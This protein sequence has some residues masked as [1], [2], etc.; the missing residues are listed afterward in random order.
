[1]TSHETLA[2]DGSVQATIFADGTR[3]VANYS[4]EK[5]DVTGAG[6]IEPQSWKTT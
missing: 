2:A 6:G 4:G 1:M 5:R 3:V